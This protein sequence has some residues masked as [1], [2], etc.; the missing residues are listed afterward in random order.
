MVNPV[1]SH[2]QKIQYLTLALPKLWLFKS[3]C[4][5]SKDGSLGLRRRAL[6]RFMAKFSAEPSSL[7]FGSC[8]FLHEQLSFVQMN[9]AEVWKLY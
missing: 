6:N 5:P 3:F 8:K 2:V 4:L 9:P 7:H 1:V